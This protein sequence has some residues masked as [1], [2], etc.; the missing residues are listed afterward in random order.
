MDGAV[1]GNGV[2]PEVLRDLQRELSLTIKDIGGGKKV[3][4]GGRG[5][6]SSSD[7]N[8]GA[9][10]AGVGGAAGAGAG[11]AGGDVM[12]A[13]LEQYSSR[14]LSMVNDRLEEKYVRKEDGESDLDRRLETTGEG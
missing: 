6:G 8:D 13:L 5:E 2:R 14:L 11:G 9:V 4:G 10:G 7:S 3:G 12:A 1:E